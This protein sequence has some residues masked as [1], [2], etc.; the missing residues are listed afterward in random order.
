MIVTILLQIIEAVVQNGIY[1]TDGER[2]RK[3]SPFLGRGGGSNGAAPTNDA[4]RFAES[5]SAARREAGW[6]DYDRVV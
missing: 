2:C 4:I 6:I 3:L 5:V 1:D